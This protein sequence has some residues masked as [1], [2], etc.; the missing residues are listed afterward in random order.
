MGKRKYLDKIE[1]LL[2]KSPVVSFKSIQRI[3]GGKS[4]YAKIVINNLLK[5]DRVMHLAKGYYTIHKDISLAVFCFKPSYLGLQSAL[6]FHGLWEQETIPIIITS[7]RVKPG[8]RAVDEMNIFIRRA[9]KDLVFGFS[10]LKD[11]DF[12]IPYSDIEKTFIDLIVFKQRIS[13]EVLSKI[14]V[15]INK[16]VLAHYLKNYSVFTRKKVLKILEKEYST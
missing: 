16:K 3:V 10:H 6:S 14:C 2:K 4:G 8:L 13:P 15:K 7:R 9:R 12:Y 1:E 11:G 5:K